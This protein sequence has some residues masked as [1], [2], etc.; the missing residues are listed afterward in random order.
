[1]K[2]IQPVSN[3]FLSSETEEKKGMEKAFGKYSFVFATPS[4]RAYLLLTGL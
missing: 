3:P 4:P 1:M 2:A